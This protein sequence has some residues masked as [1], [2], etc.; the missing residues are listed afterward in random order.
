M[1]MF[2]SLC[3]YARYPM[4]HSS[5]SVRAVSG[6]SLC[7]CRG[8]TRSCDTGELRFS[9]GMVPRASTPPRVP[10]RAQLSP[11]NP[12]CQCGM[13][14]PLAWRSPGSTPMFT[15]IQ[16]YLQERFP[17]G[18]QDKKFCSPAVLQQHPW[19]SFFRWALVQGIYDQSLQR[20]RHGAFLR[21]LLPSSCG[22]S[23]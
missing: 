1:S 19:C 22:L 12:E 21:Q 11:T 20:L 6:K 13:Y 5:S 7:K 8:S 14:W 4:Q 3:W 18:F 16:W 17:R 9:S 15:Q 2:C 23:P 10:M